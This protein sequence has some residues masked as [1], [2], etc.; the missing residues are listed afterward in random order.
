MFNTMMLKSLKVVIIEDEPIA[1]A[2]LKKL[3]GETGFAHEIIREINSVSDALAFFMQHKNY[4]LVFMDIH[5]GD[6][7]CFDILNTLE[8]EKPIV[9]CTTYDTYAIKAFKYNSIDYILKPAKAKDI[10][11]ALKKYWS[12]KQSEENEYLQRVDRM[13]NSLDTPNYKKR[14]LIRQNKK[15]KLVGTESI[16]CLYSDEGHT[17]LVEKTNTSHIVDF[18]LERLEE[19]I[20]PQMFFRINRKMIININ[21]ILSVEDYFNNRLKIKVHNRIPLE[22]VVSRNR[23]KHFKNWLK[24]VS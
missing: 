12:F 11:S 21:E 23:V 9:F 7:S 1:A 20:D 17:Y 16:V 3:I 5:L 4:D 10:H 2:Y 6:G 24:G 18:T 22:M 8:I 15:L 14:F 19:L 13:I